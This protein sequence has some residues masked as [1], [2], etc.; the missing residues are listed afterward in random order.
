MRQLL[1]SSALTL[2][3]TFGVAAPL[4][5][6]TATQATVVATVNGTDITLGHMIAFFDR[7]PAQFRDMEDQ[8]L[9][10]GILDQLVRQ[11]ILS[12]KV[13]MPVGL[14]VERTLENER[15]A[16]LANEGVNLLRDGLVSDEDIATAYLNQYGRMTPTPEFNASHILVETEEKAKEL[17]GMLEGGADFAELAKEHSTGPSGPR[18]GQLGWFGK[19]QM[20]PEFETAVAGLEKGGISGPVQTQFG[21]HVIILNDAREKPVPTMD[22]TRDQI[23]AELEESAIGAVIDGLVEAADVELK[24]EG[25]DHAVIR[26]IDLFD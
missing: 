19:G 16:L 7:L 15:R 17:I 1:L 8:R 12:A 9:F 23:K 22:E 20:V 2:G 21:W 11:E 18:G 5:A 24:T 3:L 25:M 14:R 4:A 6:Q 26:K 13:E 10:D